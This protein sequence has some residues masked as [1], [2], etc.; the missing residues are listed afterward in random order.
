MA[1]KNA[2]AQ[3]QLLNLP[4]DQI[5]VRKGFN[6]RQSMD[7]EALD[8]LAA[9]LKL[10]GMLQPV[11]AVPAGKGGAV[12]IIGGHRRL[13]AA[14]RAGLTEIPVIVRASNGTTELEAAVID[15]GHRV[16]LNPLEEAMAYARLKEAGLTEKGIAERLSV[17]Q[18][19]VTERLR[20]LELP[21]NAQAAVGDGSLG[22]K[23]V[24][25]V[26]DLANHN[27][28]LAQVL[29]DMAVEKNDGRVFSDDRSIRQAA[30][31][32][33]LIDPRNIEPGSWQLRLNTDELRQHVQDLKAWNSDY[34]AVGYA[35]QRHIGELV[36][37][38]GNLKLPNHLRDQARAAGA[39]VTIPAGKDWNGKEIEVE[40]ISNGLWLQENLP[41]A[42][43]KVH[44]A[45]NTARVKA[46]AQGKAGAAR[47]GSAVA[48]EDTVAAEKEARRK[49]REA[50]QQAQAEAREYN[51]RLGKALLTNFAS[52]QV[53]P[54]V[55]KWLCAGL[56]EDTNSNNYTEVGVYT[57]ADLAADGLRFVLPDWQT[58][59]EQKNGKRKVELPT[60]KKELRERFWDWWDKASTSEEI[61]GRTLIA[62]AAAEYAKRQAALSKEEV[63]TKG[64]IPR[65]RG[66]SFRKL[67]AKLVEH[68]L[69]GSSTRKGATT[70]KDSGR[71]LVDVL[72]ETQAPGGPLA[73]QLNQIEP[74]QEVEEE[75]VAKAAMLTKTEARVL[76]VRASHPHG[77]MGAALKP[78]FDALKVGKQPLPQAEVTRTLGSL[79]RLSLVGEQPFYDV[80]E[81]GQLVVQY[82]DAPKGDVA[83][84]ARAAELQ[85]ERDGVLTAAGR[86]AIAAV[87]ERKDAKV[88]VVLGGEDAQTWQRTRLA[89]LMPDAHPSN[90]DGIAKVI[91]TDSHTGAWV[92]RKRIIKPDP[93]KP[94]PEAE[95]A[96]PKARSQSRAEHAKRLIGERPGITIPELA[97]A[98]GV[99]QNYLYRVVP[100]LQEKGLVRKSGR[101]W[102]LADPKGQK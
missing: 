40:F 13:A 60:D 97:E 3:T 32:A 19:R 96:K 81:L 23:W 65:S 58:E 30:A 31:N 62:Y 87:K 25:T 47:S 44:K 73:E 68:K 2:A 45:A 35:G 85:W 88:V 46:I 9:S 78:T 26:A 93:P 80:T 10:H 24:A 77:E 41:P 36:S 90:P 4:P 95:V 66:D 71:P 69:P 54:D 42:I 94:E 17:A 34:S 99:A 18:R 50:K 39:L 43:A 63:Y 101:G 51:A 16:D 92:A 98:M 75:Y 72:A 52:V 64:R 82:L 22:P 84:K 83:K 49:E 89:W 53:T 20:I 14:Q 37:H 56:L 74:G 61:V 86:A 1:T 102:H 15:N 5:K 70:S 55:I 91:Y 38:G 27:M 29:T 100:V 28:R 67:L 7:D 76:K 11:I 33:G 57:V 48:S 79:R 59:V 8:E 21:P 6:P 12:N